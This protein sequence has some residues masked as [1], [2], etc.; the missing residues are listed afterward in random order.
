MSYAYKLLKDKSWNINKKSRAIFFDSL[1]EKDG[2]EY[3]VEIK[4]NT[5]RLTRWQ[6]EIMKKSRSLGFQTILVKC[7]VKLSYDVNVEELEGRNIGRVRL[8]C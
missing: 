4:T 7:N 2:N 5:A 3:L 8:R 1:V 6:E